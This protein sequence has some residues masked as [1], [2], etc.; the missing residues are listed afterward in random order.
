M[1]KEILHSIEEQK[2][3]IK[4]IEASI[5]NPESIERSNGTYIITRNPP[6]LRV[7]SKIPYQQTTQAVD[8]IF[9]KCKTELVTDYRASLMVEFNNLPFDK[10]GFGFNQW[11]NENMDTDK[12][13]TLYEWISLIQAYI[14][15]S[16]VNKQSN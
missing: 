7:I 10:V 4:Q 2:H 15:V 12:R 5:S 14:E 11:C 9:T 8:D 13:L 3:S 1:N 6:Q 16:A